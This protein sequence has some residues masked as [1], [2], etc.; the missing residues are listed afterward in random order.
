MVEFLWQPG[1]YPGFIRAA[2]DSDT[3]QVVGY[4]KVHGSCNAALGFMFPT[5][6]QE[7]SLL[8]TGPE[9]AYW[10]YLRDEYFTIKNSQELISRNVDSG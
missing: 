9:A 10:T 3:F 2:V 5:S 8:F 6:N 1:E 4:V 7:R